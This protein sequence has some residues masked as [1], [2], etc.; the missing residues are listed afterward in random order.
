MS[1]RRALAP[2]VALLL[3]VGAA[4]AHAADPAAEALFDEGLALF[5]KGD[6]AAACPKLQSAVDLTRGEALGGMLLLAECR[7]KSGMTATA[8]ALYRTIAARAARA[9]QAERQTA[10]EQG[11]ERLAPRLHRAELVIPPALAATPGVSIRRGD[12]ALP[13]EAWSTAFPVDPG[14]LVIRVEAPGH[15]PL[16][17]RVTIP[18]ETGTTRVELAALTPEATPTP[19]PASAPPATTS[20]AA[21][22]GGLG[23]LGVAGLVTGGVGVVAMGASLVVTLIAKS[24]WNEATTACPGGVCPPDAFPAAEQGVSDARSLADVG[25]VMFIGGAVLTAAGVTMVIVDLAGDDARA[26]ARAP[27]VRVSAGVGGLVARGAF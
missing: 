20:T 9:G 25:T 19:A 12:E 14:E 27:A 4:P 17:R 2:I 11:A 7:E 18:S 22:G 10:A 5:E 26:E 13:R 23:G 21:D 1:P 8:W 15:T 3:A 16:E 6:F 24:D